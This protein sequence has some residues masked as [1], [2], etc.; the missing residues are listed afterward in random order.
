M[1]GQKQVRTR[2]HTLI[3]GYDP[4][5]SSD[6]GICALYDGKLIY[7]GTV[8]MWDYEEELDIFAHFERI[9]LAWFNEDDDDPEAT[10]LF[11]YFERPQ[12]GAYF[13]RAAISE[14]AGA[15][16]PAFCMLLG[17]NKKGLSV[18]HPRDWRSLIPVA[19]GNLSTDEWKGHS[20]RF[21]KK[22]YGYDG[23]DDNISDAI[24]IAH[25]GYQKVLSKM[26]AKTSRRSAA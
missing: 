12:N 2:T 14:A 6:G 4:A 21:A 25:Y 24:C 19:S 18:V 15:S 11:L 23:G 26:N 8:R 22:H 10:M 5:K 1:K 20:L 17:G 9:R 13:A 7:S 16:F 3:V